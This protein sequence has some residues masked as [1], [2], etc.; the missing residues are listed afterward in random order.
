MIVMKETIM[1]LN[2][3]S[4]VVFQMT[5]NEKLIDMDGVVKMINGDRV[6]VRYR[7]WWY[8]RFET[9]WINCQAIKEII[10]TL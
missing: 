4:A 8:D 6:K 9:L 10:P 2:V 5:V 3:G 7:A 1:K